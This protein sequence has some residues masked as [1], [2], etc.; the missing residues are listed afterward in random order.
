MAAAA[1]L[2][3]EVSRGLFAQ[4]NRMTGDRAESEDLVQEAI[5]AALGIWD[6]FGGWSR[7]ALSTPTGRRPDWMHGR[8]SAFSPSVGRGASGRVRSSWPKGLRQVT[9]P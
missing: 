4:A 9:L 6:M 8:P 5:T 7:S 1:T 3:M 2:A